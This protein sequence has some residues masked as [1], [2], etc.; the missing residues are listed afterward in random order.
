M[1]QMGTDEDNLEE[2]LGRSPAW[3]RFF[4][5]LSSRRPQVIALPFPNVETFAWVAGVE[6]AW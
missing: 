6:G 3:K 2:G 4:W 5:L 1:G